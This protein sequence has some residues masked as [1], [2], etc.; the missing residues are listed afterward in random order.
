MDVDV[1]GVKPLKKKHYEIIAGIVQAGG[2]SIIVWGMS[3]CH[4]VGSLLIVE[5]TVDQY[6]YASVL[7]NHVYPYTR[8]VLPQDDDI[9][10]QNNMKG[11]TVNS[12]CGVR[13][14]SGSDSQDTGVGIAQHTSEHVQ[15]PN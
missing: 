5:G 12:S 2:R 13:S 9:Y 7:S 1:Y 10:Q 3:F 15:K 4:S 8:I 11:H 6:K 14:A